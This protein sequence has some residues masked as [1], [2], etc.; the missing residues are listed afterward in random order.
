MD[1]IHNLITN[2]TL[3]ELH[4]SQATSSDA[5]Q[6]QQPR[7]RPMSGMVSLNLKSKYWSKHSPTL[8]D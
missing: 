8:S 3:I 5:A 7:H 6:L 4:D 2:S 1:A